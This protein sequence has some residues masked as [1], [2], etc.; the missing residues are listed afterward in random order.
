MVLN[1]SIKCWL[2]EVLLAVCLGR[3]HSKEDN[4]AWLTTV[5]LYF[6]N[7]VAKFGIS[8][9][10]W[11]FHIHQILLTWV[12]NN[13]KFKILN[14][15]AHSSTY[16]CLYIYI[17]IFQSFIFH[18]PGQM[19]IRDLRDRVANG[20]DPTKLHEAAV[21]HDGP[22]DEQGIWK[23]YLFSFSCFQNGRLWENIWNTR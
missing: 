20:G 7:S 18:I 14:H 1:I 6:V 8:L 12:S 9:I 22:V 21:E 13:N 10:C 17:Y 2:K 11:I 3:G 15:V 4:L 23:L 16:T 19:C 5:W